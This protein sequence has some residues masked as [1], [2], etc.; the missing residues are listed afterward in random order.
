MRRDDDNGSSAETLQPLWA[1]KH[2]AQILVFL[3]STSQIQGTVRNT[4][5]GTS[6]TYLS[7]WITMRNILS[8][9]QSPDSKNYIYALKLL[10]Q[11]IVLQSGLFFH[12]LLLFFFFFYI[13][14]LYLQGF[15]CVCG[16]FAFHVK[17]GGFHAP[18]LS[19]D[20]N[21]CKTAAIMRCV[22]KSKELVVASSMMR[23]RV[24]VPRQPDQGAGH[25]HHRP[26]YA[27]G[28]PSCGYGAEKGGWSFFC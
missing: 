17:L 15:F 13:L 10:K 14:K 18:V 2:R 6:T 20:G 27:L 1:E 16:N 23:C 4:K 12:Y 3:S 19:E 28:F 25:S 7:W 8:R 11:M 21:L 24:L 9:Q 26:P 22:A 5:Q